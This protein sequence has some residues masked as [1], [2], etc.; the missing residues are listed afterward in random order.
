MKFVTIG[1]QLS[2][3]RLIKT[4]DKWVGETGANDFYAQIGDTDYKPVNM[5]WDN[6]VDPENFKEKF[7][8][9]EIIIS[10]A[11]MGT[12]ISALEVGKPILV[13]PREKKFNEHRND[14]QI[15]TARSFLKMNAIEVAFDENELIEKLNNLH[16]IKPKL[17]INPHASH[18]LLTTLSDF[19][20]NKK[21]PDPHL[22]WRH[23]F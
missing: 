16:L 23:Q 1:T 11:G 20:N 7:L 8:S 12:I 10:H 21:E 15:D 3:N 5:K 6:F 14:H 19:I 4:I 22:L 9:A 2:F 13:L 18:E 17:K